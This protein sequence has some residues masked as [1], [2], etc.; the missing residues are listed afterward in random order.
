M[1]LYAD[2]ALAPVDG[3]WSAWGPWSPCTSMGGAGCG[4]AAGWRERRRTC[5]NPA[6]K[7][8]GTDCDGN[9]ID[10]Q[11]CDMRPCELRKATAWTRWVQIH[12][13]YYSTETEKLTV[14]F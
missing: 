13:E 8:G 5:T 3:G 4:P 2:P 12:S 10:R 9:K 11:L 1:L 14:I 7:H 6:P